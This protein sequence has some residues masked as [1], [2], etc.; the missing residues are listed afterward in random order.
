M[1]SVVE[2]MDDFPANGSTT[3]DGTPVNGVGGGSASGAPGQSSAVGPEASV[4]GA[5][6]VVEG[7]ES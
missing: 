6:G 7:T 2:G 5:F 4:Q 1:S 3:A